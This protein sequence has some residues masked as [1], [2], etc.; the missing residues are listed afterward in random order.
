MI[1]FVCTGNTCR[2]PMAKTLLQRKIK[3]LGVDIAVDS[4]GVFVS[5]VGATKGAINAMKEMDLDLTSHMPQQITANHV[6]QA[7]IVL[8]MT[9][10]HKD[11]V[12]SNLPQA[13]SKTYTLHEY[14]TKTKKDVNDPYGGSD[15]D[16]QKTARELEDLINKMKIPV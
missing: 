15:F 6:E 10:S 7:T 8:T 14:A 3:E 16:Y 11:V 1:L 5:E 2:S 12:I 9:S 13:A 4:C